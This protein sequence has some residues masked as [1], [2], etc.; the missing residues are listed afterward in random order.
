MGFPRQSWAAHLNL[1]KSYQ[2]AILS[3][4]NVHLNRPE[5]N[6]C[7]DVGRQKR[8]TKQNS[9]PKNIFSPVAMTYAQCES[10]KSEVRF[11]WGKQTLLY[12]IRV[13]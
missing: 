8:N 12:Q 13:R 9:L 4:L 3:E 6:M 11:V 5:D 7:N 2:T 1:Q 10:Q